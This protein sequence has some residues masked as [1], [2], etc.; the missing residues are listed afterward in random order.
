VCC[1]SLR[2]QDGQ[3]LVM[4]L[5]IAVVGLIVV[6]GAVGLALETG[7]QATHDGRIRGAQQAA[8]AGVQQQLYLQSDSNGVGYNVTAGS[9]GSL[10]DCVEPTL[11]V[12][13]Q[14]TGVTLVADTSGSCPQSACPSGGTQCT[15]S[16]STAWTPVSNENYFESR[17]LANPHVQASASQN[18]SYDVLFPEILSIGC[19]SAAATCSTAATTNQYS[20]QLMVLQPTAPLQ[21]VEGQ[22]NVSITGGTSALASAF[23]LLGLGTLCSILNILCPTLPITTVTGNV[24]AGYNLTLPAVTVGG[25]T[26]L[27]SYLTLSGLTSLVTNLSGLGATL[28]YGHSG[29]CKQNGDTCASGAQT[30]PNSASLLNANLVQTTATPC[31]AGQP[32]S[33]GTACNLERSTFTVSTGP[34]SLTQLN[35]QL[36]STAIGTSCTGAINYCNGDLN[37]TSG[38]LDLKAGTYYFCNVNVTGGTFEGPSTSGSSG[39]VQIFVLPDNSSLCTGSGSQGSFKVTPGISNLLS[40]T[41]SLPLDGVTGA[42]DPSAVQIYVAGDPSQNG[43]LTVGSS[44]TPNSTVTIGGSGISVEQAAVVY[45]PR[46]TVNIS[47]T[48]IFEG[49]AI[50]WNVNMEAAA[51]IEDLDLGNYPLSSVINTLQPAQTVECD[52]NEDQTLSYTSSDLTG[53]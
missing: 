42:V 24:T 53:C 8:D 17:Y 41:S 19:H 14:I 52:S 5:L 9:I 51:I 26:N 29:S 46:S 6:L 30:S 47:T 48:G 16:L 38:T 20:R 12:S 3:A 36:S 32:P 23:S 13:A 22:N 2:D 7:S 39:A 21:A 37:M 50:G 34:M 18:S 44:T 35:S 31:T 45:A 25:N 1:S 11:N 10:L 15:G 43:S 40:S 33:S 28:Q 27:G 49:S 4:A